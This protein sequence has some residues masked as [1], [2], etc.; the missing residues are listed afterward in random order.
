MIKSNDG[1]VEANGTWTEIRANLSM[2]L[3]V[4]HRWEP[5]IVEDSLKMYEA[6][7]GK[8]DEEIGKYLSS[9]QSDEIL[10]GKK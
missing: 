9:A 6:L 3:I 4:L 8:T 5:A 1:R 7:K 10:E 2:L